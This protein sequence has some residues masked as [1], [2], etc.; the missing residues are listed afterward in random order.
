[1]QL[2]KLKLFI[3]VLL[4]F[5][6]LGAAFKV[7]VLVEGLT[8]VRPVNAIP[9]VAGLIAGPIGALACGIGNLLA[10][11]TGSFGFR[12]IL[13][14]FANFVAAYLPFR[15]W[16]LFSKEA[17][18]LHGVKNIM[19]YIFISLVN[20]F[21]TAWFLSYGLSTFF[22]EWIEQI[23][24][25]VFFNNFGFSVGL[26]MPLMIVMT[27]DS[28]NILC[29]KRLPHLILD[30]VRIKIPVIAVY[31]V[32]MLIVFITVIFLHISPQEYVWL[33]IISAL[34]FL[35]LLVLII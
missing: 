33:H 15:L 11:L 12:S 31:L 1:M 9:P 28:I 22:G 19:L 25:Y 3:I 27:S 18:N 23:Y 5:F 32:L 8:E 34:S 24:V 29:A 20:A 4:A 14:I 10:D 17:P 6:V 35:G 13:G 16:H 30:R 26:G 2:S 21:T 7:M